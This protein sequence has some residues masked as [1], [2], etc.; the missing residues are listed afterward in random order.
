MLESVASDN[1]IIADRT[2][3]KKQAL[4]L[5]GWLDGDEDFYKI[6]RNKIKVIS[7]QKESQIVSPKEKGETMRKNCYHRPDG[8]WEYSKQIDGIKYYA[9]ASTYRDLIKKIDNATSKKVRAVSN[10]RKKTMSFAQYFQF[11]IDSFI[12]NKD[13][14]QA[15]KNDWER[16]QR[17]FIVKNF[18]KVDLEK[19]TAEK[20]QVMID[21]IKLERLRERVYQKVTKVLKKA[22]I[23]GRIKRDIS[24][25][26]E[27]PKRKNVIVRESLT[28]EE[29]KAFIEAMKK[30]NLYTFAMFLLVIG[31]RRDEAIK[32][33]A[34][35][36]LDVEKKFIHIRGTKTKNAD[37]RVLVSDGFIKFLQENLPDGKFK[38]SS[39]YATHIIG[40]A[41]KEIGTNKCLH[42]LRHTCSANLYFLGAKDKFRQIQLG[43]ASIETT[44]DIYTHISENIPKSKLLEIYGDL[45]PRFDET[46]DETFFTFYSH[47]K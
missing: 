41:L 14:V 36:D 8:R 33:N 10:P 1:K 32:F 7:T 24:L 6:K 30:T 13:Y 18:S 21:G 46:F 20:V 26:L 37:R 35:T 29:Q 40:D 23:T 42:C 5:V 47:K 44:N 17:N 43:H 22:Y 2:E 38:F 19:L 4:L 31:C 9:I 45:Y 16:T 3:H 15:T 11:Y 28:L 34:K 12:K 25:A 39:Q 27:K